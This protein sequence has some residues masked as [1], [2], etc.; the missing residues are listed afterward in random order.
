[1]L[2]GECLL[3]F[4]VYDDLPDVEKNEGKVHLVLFTSGTVL[5]NKKKPGLYYSDGKNWKRVE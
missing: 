3:K 5:V 1:M 2:I 4:N